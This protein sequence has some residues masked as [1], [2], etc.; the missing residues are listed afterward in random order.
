MGWR[1]ADSRAIVGSRARTHWGRVRPTAV[2]SWRQ[3]FETCC[4]LCS[5][6]AGLEH[7]RWKT[8]LRED[9]KMR[10]ISVGAMLFGAAMLFGTAVSMEV[11]A[12][13]EPEKELYYTCKKGFVFQVAG[14]AARCFNANAWTECLVSDPRETNKPICPSSANLEWNMNIDYGYVPGPS[15]PWDPP[16]PPP[17][18]IWPDICLANAGGWTVIAEPKCPD[19]CYLL[20]M[21]K[22]D[23]C[24]KAVKPAQPPTVG[25]WLVTREP[26]EP[27]KVSIGRILGTSKEK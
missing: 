9:E 13:E 12:Q 14:R 4:L 19:G 20:P 15:G 24:V 25:V 7:T 1:T 3:R 11:F 5:R 10:R 16:P 27:R 18:I 17:D 22:N 23:R 21:A 6:S 26:E 8:K 2:G